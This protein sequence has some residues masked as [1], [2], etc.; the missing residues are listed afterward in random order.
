ML[1]IGLELLTGRYVATAY[2][3]RSVAEWPPHPARLFSALVATWH[4]AD[5]AGADGEGE[6]MALRYVERL[7]APFILCSSVEDTARR[8]AP[9]VFVPVND[10]ATVS[11]PETS[12]LLAAEEALAAAS[13][14][15]SRKKATADVEK[16]RKKLLDDT[17][18][19]VAAPSKF[20]ADR[21][22]GARVLP[23]GRTRQPRTF[24]SVTPARAALAF[25]W[26]DEELPA[27]VRPGLERLLRRLIRLGH[28][29]SMVA[30]RLLDE[31]AVTSL[32]TQTTTFSPDDVQGSHMLRWVNRGQVERL[33]RAFDLHQEVEPRVLPATFVRY[34]EG[35][36]STSETPAVGVFGHHDMVVFARVG[37]P[38]LPM[39]ST[40]GVA[41]Q[42]RRALL[43]AAKDDIP[44]LLSGHT[45]DGAALEETHVA[46]VPLP[47]VGGPHADGAILGI[48]LVF[49]RAAHPDERRRVLAAIGRLEQQTA[50]TDDPP[51]IHLKL[52]ETGVLELQRVA[53]GEDGRSTLQP[54]W[55]SRSSTT[56]ASATPVALDRHP[57]NLHDED[58]HRRHK[59]FDEA[60]ASVAIAVKRAGY[61]EPV[62]LDV[63]RSC[64]LPGSVKPRNFPR[65]PVETDRPQRV[66]VH[67]RLVFPTSVQGPIILGAGRYMGL[68]L[69]LP[70]DPRSHAASTP[71]EGA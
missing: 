19:A 56:W 32:S 16:L 35:T 3:D 50:G 23:E 27:E 65:F 5:P 46:F 15:R 31:A 68:G 8:T 58:P 55:W 28:S 62:E 52:G 49:P 42:F 18:K 70:V 54:G 26:R 14:E 17:A 69:H 13:D 2:N 57:G 33:G 38:R 6:L 21:D 39:T 60:R 24:P 48:G 67:T 30:A 7:P 10:A 44:A 37:G 71:S 41:R 36:P 20:T 45:P 22:L 51:V 63:V 59:A 12:K 1:A 25:V 29:S 53:W 43:A 4:D 9:P 11:E 66:L 61:P 47:V 40:V 34:R 64:V